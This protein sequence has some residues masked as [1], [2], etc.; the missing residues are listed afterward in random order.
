M[1]EIYVN[2]S[3]VE[4]LIVFKDIGIQIEK[5]TLTGKKIVEF[6]DISKLKDIIIHEVTKNLIE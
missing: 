3:F 2:F 5:K 1:H 4:S 6:V